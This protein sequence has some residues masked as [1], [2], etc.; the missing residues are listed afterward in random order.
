[1]LARQF[2]ERRHALGL[3][4]A[5]VARRAGIQQI[6]VSRFERGGDM[7]LSTLLRLVGALE[8]ELLAV[9]RGAAT[10]P[11]GAVLEAEQEPPPSLLDRFRVPDDE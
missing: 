3:T 6:Q 4:Q 10:L 8:L 7:R 11:A 5:D 1:M 2:R 9:P